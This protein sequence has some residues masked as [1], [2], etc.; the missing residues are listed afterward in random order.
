MM[1]PAA[2]TLVYY[3]NEAVIQLGFIAFFATAFPF[4]PLFS[5]LTNLLEI[6]IK[7]QHFEKYGR[8]NKAEATSGVGNWMSIMGFISYF[9]IPMNVIILL[10]CRFPTKQI[11]ASQD[12][13]N[14]LDEEESVLVQW[15]HKR[16]PAFWNRANVILVAILTEHLIIALKIVIAL[17]IPDVPKKVVETEFRRSKIETQVQRELLDIKYKGNHESFQD[18]T[19]R[20][21]REAAKIIEDQV[22]A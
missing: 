6:M 12:L 15:L 19:E 1:K 5:F 3:Y 20:L 9:A 8:R 16:D 14:L 18:I 17:I 4:A 11:G 2:T 13:D 7:M 22:Q 21:Q 10:I